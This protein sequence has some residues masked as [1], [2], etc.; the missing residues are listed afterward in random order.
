VDVVEAATVDFVDLGQDLAYLILEVTL[1]QT[2]TTLK[3]I[4][5]ILE[6]LLLPQNLIP[7]RHQIIRMLLMQLRLLGDERL[8]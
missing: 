7:L 8:V 5:L 3:L 1:H 2:P 6:P 4:R